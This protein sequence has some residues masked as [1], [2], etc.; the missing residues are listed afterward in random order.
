[1]LM[2]YR[3]MPRIIAGAR[4]GRVE[5]FHVKDASALV[6]SLR[7]AARFTPSDLPSSSSRDTR[8]E[9]MKLDILASFYGAKDNRR[10]NRG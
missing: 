2:A 8:I 10:R 5:D 4:L 1:M 3:M 6:R 7:T 9:D